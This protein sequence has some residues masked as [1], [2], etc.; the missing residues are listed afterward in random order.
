[1]VNR[2][3]VKCPVCGKFY[4]IKIQ[5]DRNI[6]I[7]DWPICFECKECGEPIHLVF[8]N[9]GLLPKGYS[10]KLDPQEFPVTTI[11]YSSSLPITDEIYMKDL[12]DVQ[13]MV[14]FSVFMNLTRSSFSDIEV[15][16]FNFY[17][18]RLQTNLLP[19]K[20]ILKAL[21]PILK[22]GNCKAFS[23]KMA[24]F[25]NI[26][27]YEELSEVKAMYDIYFEL[28]EKSHLNLCPQHY[29]DNFYNPFI[30]P[31]IDYLSGA[32]KPVLEA[33]K[34]Q[35]DESGKISLWYRDEALPYIARMLDSIQLF[36]P[37][38]LFV[39]A[40]ERN[41]RNRGDLKIVTISFKEAISFY[42]DGYE[43]LIH[44]LKII[45]GLNNL[46]ENGDI[47]LF[48][49]PKLGD[50][51]SI[52][53]FAN[54]SGGKM[55]EH[56]EDYSSVSNYLGGSLNNKVRNA[57]S[58]GEQGIEYTPETQA[59]RCFYDDSD[60]AKYYDTSLIEIC[61]MC[62]LQLLHLMETT[63]VARIIVDKSE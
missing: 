30:K 35:L 22:K 7:Y 58:H 57:A 15:S 47:N 38:M 6:S 20:G 34:S 62:F 23:K 59:V 43:A 44:G 41:V 12:D 31:I 17:L 33:I 11:G 48:T 25:F 21:L 14:L 8:G 45:V 32:S 10:S 42:K 19:Y 61:R 2:V 39:C 60:R 56:L 40:G 46:L 51:D 36:I 9:K 3:Y 55:L 53:K 52:T 26:K 1:M 37:V 18:D 27:Q 24:M 49:N 54:K 16:N 5:I 13:S 4:Q 28:I 29:L 63:L 50:V